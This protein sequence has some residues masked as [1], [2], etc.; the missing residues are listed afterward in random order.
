[1]RTLAFFVVILLLSQGDCDKKA[2]AQNCTKSLTDKPGFLFLKT[3]DLQSAAVAELSYVFMRGNTYLIRVC[4][5]KDEDIKL[6]L[7]DNERHKLVD[8]VSMGKDSD[9]V[10]VVF[11]CA[12]TGIYYMKFS[13]GAKCGV[14]LLA[15][16][17][18][19]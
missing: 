8:W 10:S 17:K 19:K 13:E 5:E 12:A 16:S 9:Y 14:G 1:M 2:A 11:P 6:L 15:F 3:V 7:E 4:K 18:T